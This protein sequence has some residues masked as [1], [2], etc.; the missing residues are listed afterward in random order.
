MSIKKKINIQLNNFINNINDNYIKDIT[1]NI[2][3]FKDNNIFIIGVGKNIPLCIYFADILKS[4][5]YSA[6]NINCLNLTHGDIG[7]IRKNDLIIIISNSGNTL[8]LIN[9]IKYINNNN[10]ILICTNKNAKLIEYCNKSYIFHKVEELDGKF[11]MIPCTS[12]TTFTILFN[13]LINNIMNNNNI[14]I[15]DYNYNHPKGNIGL[16]SKKVKDILIPFEDT[17]KNYITD[18]I[19]TI[20][21]NMFKFKEGYSCIIDKDNN[22]IGIITDYNIRNYILKENHCNIK[23]LN[24]IITRKYKYIDDL[25]MNIYDAF[26]IKKLYLPVIINN[27]LLG[28]IKNINI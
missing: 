26:N 23:D 15:E 16:I 18:N 22:M 12:I 17:C 27:K 5:N 8:E 9:N 28:I 3:K 6:F 14:T 20:I 24:N 25:E 4:I 21:I 2:L 1:E 10:K 7:C 13:L 11:N 19:N